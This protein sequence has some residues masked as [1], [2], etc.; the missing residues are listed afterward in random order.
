MM[1]ELNAKIG[2]DNEQYES[3]IGREGVGERNDNGRKFVDI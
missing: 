2:S 1:R 3:C